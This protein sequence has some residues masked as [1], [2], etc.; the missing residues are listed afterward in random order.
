MWGKYSKY[1]V[2]KL[3]N[4]NKAIKENRV[5]L[6]NSKALIKYIFNL[7]ADYGGTGEIL[8]EQKYENLNFFEFKA[9][10]NKAIPV[11][12]IRQGSVCVPLESRNENLNINYNAITNVNNFS[13]INSNISTGPQ[14]FPSYSNPQPPGQFPHPYPFPFLYRPP[15]IPGMD[16]FMPRPVNLADYNQATPNVLQL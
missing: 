13:S 16:M 5:H 4:L 7:P 8:D 3:L 15:A 14:N 6:P 10:K 1:T 2:A 11:I 9:G 12:E